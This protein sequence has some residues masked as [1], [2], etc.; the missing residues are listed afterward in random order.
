MC[1]LGRCSIV[2]EEKLPS[3]AAFG[4]GL[5]EVGSVCVDVEDHVTSDVCQHYLWVSAAV[6]EK[7][8]YQGSWLESGGFLLGCN[9]VERHQEI[10]V[11]CPCIVDILPCKV[12]L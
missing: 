7:V 11:Y 1:I 12:S 5:A 10:V 9:S 4:L 2:A 6:V 3:Y 8:C